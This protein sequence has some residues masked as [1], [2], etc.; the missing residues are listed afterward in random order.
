AKSIIRTDFAFA[1]ETNAEI[2][3][4][5]GEYEVGG[6]MEDILEFE[7]ALQKVSK[8]DVQRVARLYLDP[9]AYVSV[10][11]KPGGGVTNERGKDAK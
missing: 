5:I 11:V 2:A 10:V 7:A 1:T 3:A 9:A 6:S 8:E 4:L